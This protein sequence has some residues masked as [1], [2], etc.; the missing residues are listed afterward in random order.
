MGWVAK[1]MR[2]LPNTL[3]DKLLSGRPRK[4][5]KNED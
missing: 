2:V 4:H 1:A 5:R 3:F